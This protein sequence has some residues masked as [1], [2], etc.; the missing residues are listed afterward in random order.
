MRAFVIHL[1][2]L[3]LVACSVVSTVPWKA[4]APSVRARPG[5][6]GKGFVS[7]PAAVAAPISLTA[8]DGTGLRLASL[9]VHGVV[10]DPLAL[11]ELR[12][13][14]ENPVDR[15]IEGRFEI[16][17]P[18]GA[19]V[20]RFAMKIADAWQ[21]GEVVE[22]QRA[23]VAYESFLHR[24]QDPALLEVDGSNKF[25]ARVFPIAPRETKQLILS[26]TQT[27]ADPEQPYGVALR[28]LPRVD[29]L[30]VRVAVHNGKGDPQIHAW[31]RRS[32]RP[33][34]DLVVPRT[35]ASE[36]ALR[37]DGKVLARIQ[38]AGPVDPGA[39]EE[40]VHSLA[41]LIDTSASRALDF[42]SSLHQLHGVLQRLAEDEPEARL[43]VAAFDQEYQRVFRGTLGAFKARDLQRIRD[44]H[45]LGASNLDLALRSLA[46]AKESYR[47][48]LLITDGVVT[49]G[50]SRKRGFVERVAGLEQMGARRLDVLVVGGIRDEAG[51]KALVRGALPQAGLTLDASSPSSELVRR[52]RLPTLSRIRVSM[53][54]AS[55]VSP[56]VIDGVQPGDHVL[57]YAD[58]PKTGKVSVELRSGIRRSIRLKATRRA[59]PLFP[60]AWVAGRVQALIG[61]LE[62]LPEAE[63][64]PELRAKIVKLSTQNRILNELT[65]LL[66]LETDHDYTRFGINRESLA[67]ILAVDDTGEVQLETRSVLRSVAL[68]TAQRRDVPVEPPGPESSEWQTVQPKAAP[69][70]LPSEVTTQVTMDEA[71]NI[72]MGD[73]SHEFTSVV[74]MSDVATRDGAGISLA[75]IAEGGRHQPPPLPPSVTR[76]GLKV[77]G[78]LR[79]VQARRTL[80]PRKGGMEACYLARV[81][82]GLNRS[83]KISLALAIEPTGVVGSTLVWKNTVGDPELVS[84][85]E[86]V[87]QRL[88]FQVQG[89]SHVVVSYRFRRGTA[90]MP[91][92]RD[93]APVQPRT[94][95]DAHQGTLAR[96]KELVAEGDGAA[97]S[98]M[99][100]AWRDGNP[101][102]VLALVALGEVLEAQGE[103][104]LAARAYGS[105]VDLFPSRADMIRFAGNRLDRVGRRGRAMAVHAYRRARKQRPD[106][107]SSH[108]LL[109]YALLRRGGH[110]EAFDALE[111]GLTRKYPNGRFAAVD[112]VFR[113]DLEI[114]GAAWLAKHPEHRSKIEGRLAGLGLHPADKPSL[115]FVLSWESDANDV[116]LHILDTFGD[117]AFFSAPTLRSGGEL[118]A[119]VTTGYGPE[120]FVIPGQP[121][122]GPYR[123]QVHYYSRGPMGYGMGTVQVIRHDGAGEVSL[124]DHPFVVMTDGAY[125]DL[126]RVR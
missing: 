32:Q 73:T 59:D 6:R 53:K 10:K 97:A 14:F 111:K 29:D 89:P 36:F 13:A 12:L 124:Q 50:R 68:R 67:G 92:P 85:V 88:R 21:E 26:Y 44:R 17:L 116:D 119:D 123:L 100:W 108:R 63:D 1:F 3:L 27:F 77:R 82:E 98:R 75:G 81:R 19:R 118:Y 99:A 84:C 115:R 49:A 33:S 83:G 52:L 113:D 16:A 54:G 125:V 66:V 106:H 57:V 39:K 104:R 114:V 28:G 5:P 80:A 51:L 91:A 86:R 87:F 78:S 95:P 47:R 101:G 22:K 103:H 35:G 126:G 107:P 2:G 61:T 41:V 79:R 45:P 122:A 105:I 121:V 110:A 109:A 112:R 58:G 4:P 65:S 11:T 34:D 15:R 40:G 20:T 74:E 43:Y 94:S 64:R 102:D 120:A 69:V 72:P 71:R 25:R 37:G 23:R 46:R 76:V 7:R 8:S 9:Q 117:H 93:P 62:D 70:R 90:E 42:E 18:P 96:V 31:S 38:P 55:W 48:V 30:R 56:S 24:R 60:R